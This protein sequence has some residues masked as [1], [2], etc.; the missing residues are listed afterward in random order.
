VADDRDEVRLPDVM[1]DLSN[2]YHNTLL[3]LLIQNVYYDRTKRRTKGYAPLVRLALM[4]Y[5]AGGPLQVLPR[6]AIPPEQPAPAGADRQNEW[7][8]KATV[9]DDME[10]LV[11]N[12]K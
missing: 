8:D 5:F 3:D 2:S 12:R 10:S 11:F 1:L 4:Q 6:P 7:I 9:D